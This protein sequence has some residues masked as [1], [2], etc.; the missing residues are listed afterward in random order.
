MAR[1]AGAVYGGT[2]NPINAANLNKAYK[3]LT[4]MNEKHMK[5]RLNE[6]SMNNWLYCIDRAF[7]KSGIEKRKMDYLAIL[8]I[9]RS[10][11]EHMLQ[12]LNLKPEQSFYLEHIGHAG[13]IDQIISIEHGL[14]TGKIKDRSIIAQIAAGIGYAWA[15]NIIRWG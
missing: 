1:D 4:L 9:K 5:D 14:K 3:S 13:Q 12:L 6:V 8:H 10:M 7:E 15:A 11:H 2:V